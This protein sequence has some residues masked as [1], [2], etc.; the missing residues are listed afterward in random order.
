MDNTQ[1][2]KRTEPKAVSQDCVQGHGQP[3]SST[4]LAQNDFLGFEIAC[5][6][7]Q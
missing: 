1:R 2:N 5:K 4:N 3:L 7:L 6:L